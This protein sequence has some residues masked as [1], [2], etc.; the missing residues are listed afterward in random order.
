MGSFLFLASAEAGV[1]GFGL[2]F[3]IFESNIINLSI[4]IVLAFNF[5]RSFLTNVLTERRERIATAIKEAEDKLKKAA[6]DLAE[7]QQKL[8]Q[9][10]VE[11]DQIRS[12]GEK[13]AE[14]AKQSILAK[15]EQ[16][17][18]TMKA[19]AVRDV[20]SEREKAIAELRQRVSALAVERAET[21]VRAQLDSSA[22]EKL[23]DRS[24]S[25]LGGA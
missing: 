11:A 23:I 3:D 7:Q 13:R 9:A 10:K 14:L 5:L 16:D 19:N 15:A 6:T 4:V 1:N 20:E 24:L 25:L 8:A 22:Q 17:V 2:K 12:E 18:E 21:Q